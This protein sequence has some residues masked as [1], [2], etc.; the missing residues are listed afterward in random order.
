MEATTSETTYRAVIEHGKDGELGYS[1]NA[2]RID[3]ADAFADAERLREQVKGFGYSHPVRV[4]VQQT[5]TTTTTTT[6][7]ITR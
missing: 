4:F 6:T 2:T 7:E 5:V 1:Y 3:A